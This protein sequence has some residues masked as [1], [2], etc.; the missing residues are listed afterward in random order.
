MIPIAKQADLRDYGEC[1]F[2]A[3]TTFYRTKVPGR[4]DAEQVRCCGWCAR[5]RHPRP[6]WVAVAADWL[7]SRLPPEVVR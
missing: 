1:A 2:C 6:R 3:R 4:P 7:A 5:R